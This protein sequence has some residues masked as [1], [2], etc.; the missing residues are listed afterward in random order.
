MPPA[1]DNDIAPIVDTSHVHTLQR[2]A[3]GTGG[4]VFMVI[5]AAAPLTIVAGVAPLAILI[6]GVSA[7]LVY[8][9]AGIILA[10]FAVAFMAMT[11]HVKALGGFYT[12]ITE[13]L[14]K[15]AGLGAS[16]VALVSYNALQIGLYGMMGTAGHDLLQVEFG[17]DVP[18]WLIAGV[19]I[20]AVFVVAWRGIDVGAKVLG[21]LLVAETLILLVLAVAI[22]AQGGAEGITFGTFDPANIFTPGMF[23]VMGMGFA[24]FMG[25][26]STA[27]YREEAR[28]PERTIPRA[29]YI[30]VVFMALFYGFIVWTIVVGVGESNVV[31]AAAENTAGLVF[32]TASDYLG[33]W[34]ELVMYLL[35]LTSVYASQLAFHNAINRYTFSLARDGVLPRRLYDTDPKTHSPVVSGLAQTAL[36][37]LVVAVF[38]VLGMDPYLQLLLWVNSP[39]VVGI[40]VLQ[41]LTC[42]AV[43]V[44]FVKRPQLAR[45]WYVLPAAIVAGLAMTVILVILCLTFDLLTAASPLVNG[46]LIAITPVT[47][48]VGVVLAV[49]WKRTRPDVYARIGGHRDEAETIDA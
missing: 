47:F 37:A 31:G 49:R 24:A 10:I 40:I 33:G 30:S 23:A 29:T 36:A 38:A 26:E 35:I 20:A 8:T 22:L 25:F 21:V 3:L 9:I 18:W 5:S 1:T 45:R 6:G 42:I 34:A 16:L 32:A 13:A 4:I 19:G 41:I 12:Y 27:L 46:L 15:A 48:L 2:N 43:V 17:I 14:G 39:G 11:K 44:F 7:P 28:D